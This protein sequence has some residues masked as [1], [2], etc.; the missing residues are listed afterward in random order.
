MAS[1]S[2][3]HRIHGSTRISAR[4]QS[5]PIRFAGRAADPDSGHPLLGVRLPT[6]RPTWLI[7]LDDARLSYLTD[8][9]IE[10]TPVYPA[11]AY[12]EAALAAHTRLR[13]GTRTSIEKVTFDRMLVL[14]PSRGQQLEIAVDPE[15]HFEISSRSGEGDD[16]WSLHARGALRDDLATTARSQMDLAALQIRCSRERSVAEMYERLRDIGLEYDGVFRCVD[17]VWEGP[18]E[19]LGK[20]RLP[21]HAGA[22]PA[23]YGVHPAILD[24]AI[25]LLVAAQL[26]GA[27]ARAGETFLPVAIECIDLFE[28]VGIE[29]WVHAEITRAT[30]LEMVGRV[31][32]MNAH[33][34]VTLDLQQIRAVRVGTRTGG[35]REEL[36]LHELRWVEISLAEP[37]LDALRSPSDIV[38]SLSTLP[39]LSPSER[40]RRAYASVRDGL[41]TLAIAWIPARSGAPGL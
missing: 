7:D 38:E 39:P 11:A 33:G 36:C 3:C 14:S 25:Q 27:T 22:D 9:R 15:G 28:P 6:A 30:S 8:H 37:P 23:S 21:D 18:A 13:P 35:E 20:V 32:I 41:N 31:R 10:D 1:A 5:L 17:R 24:G 29:C 16:R 12:I 40:S 26:S 34:D 2:R 19:A 4:A